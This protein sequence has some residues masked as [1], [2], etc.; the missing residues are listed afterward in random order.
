MRWERGTTIKAPR[1]GLVGL[2]F[3]VVNSASA[4]VCADDAVIESIQPDV[5]RGMFG[6]SQ[7]AGRYTALP[8]VGAG[9]VGRQTCNARG[10]HRYLMSV[11]PLDAQLSRYMCMVVIVFTTDGFQYPMEVKFAR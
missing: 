2:D 10:V 5:E 6:C 7:P 4:T 8:R 1:N 3:S 11:E 9:A